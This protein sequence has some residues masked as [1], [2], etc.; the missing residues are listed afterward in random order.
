MRTLT[1]ALALAMSLKAAAAAETVVVP[2]ETSQDACA[3]IA[4]AKLQQ[5]DQP[6]IAIQQTKTLR[7]GHASTVDV[8]LTSNTLYFSEGSLWHSANITMAKRAARSAAQV[9]DSMGL[10]DCVRGDHVT[11]AGKLA[12]AYTYSQIGASGA[13]AAQGA[14]WIEDDN[15]LPIRQE[16]TET[17]PPANRRVAVS[18]VATYSYND[19]VQVPTAAQ[20]A[21]MGRLWAINAL[22][23]HQG[24]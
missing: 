20:H 17:A 8:I 15:G 4:E 11:E 7:D 2:G 14:I 24:R 9:E 1:V 5:W 13:D 3:K 22:L 21:E 6:R 12:T 23:T 19:A 16:M 10:T 18:M